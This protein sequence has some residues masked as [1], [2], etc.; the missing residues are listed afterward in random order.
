MAVT[1]IEYNGKA[2]IIDAFNKLE[3]ADN[4]TV[5]VGYEDIEEC[6]IVIEDTGFCSIHIEKTTDIQESFRIIAYKG[7]QGPCFD[8]GIKAKYNGVAMAAVDDDNHLLIKGREL[9]VCEKTAAVY[10][11]RPY[12]DFIECTTQSEGHAEILKSGVVPFNCNTFDEDLYQLNSQ[13]ENKTIDSNRTYLFYSGP[14]KFLILNDGS[15]VRR[16]KINNVPYS[17]KDKLVE[18]EGFIHLPERGSNLSAVSFTDIYKRYGAASFIE[19]FSGEFISSGREKSDMDALMHL[20]TSLKKRIEDVIRN[21]KKY[22]ILTGSDP[23]EL[24]GC[25]PSAE[26]EEAVMLEKAGILSRY[27]QPIPEGA[28]PINIFAFKNEINADG[29]DINFTP[30]DEFRKEVIDYITGNRN[31]S[32][33]RYI[34]VALLLFVFASL[35]LLVIKNIQTSSDD[36]DTGLFE[37]LNPGTDDQLMIVL[38]H[39][40]ERCEMCLNL[41]QYTL[42]FLENN[43]LT[44]G[45]E[46]QFT[47]VIIDDAKN[48]GI[49]RDFN[50]YTSTLMLVKFEG[51]EEKKVRVIEN[52]WQF[53]RD[54]DAFREM[55]SLEMGKFILLNYE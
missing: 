26:V 30:D 4:I 42:S 7:K 16:G 21:K 28:C 18:E 53:Y 11:F 45:E 5:I 40:N 55:L 3:H 15:L 38:F 23:S 36:G 41:E 10:D 50:I 34:R 32:V 31:Q 1:T 2:A 13:L 46:L 6:M 25:C 24:K 52:A 48:A 51:T 35:T 39:Y 14:F 22:F 44:Y 47:R 37:L 33:L 54:E 8:T 20:K 29:G 12:N 17:L 27:A 49:I 19:N 9:P 43:E